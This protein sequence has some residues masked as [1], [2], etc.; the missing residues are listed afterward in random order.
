MVSWLAIPKIPS[1]A[2]S[3]EGK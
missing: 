3:E 1:S 2:R